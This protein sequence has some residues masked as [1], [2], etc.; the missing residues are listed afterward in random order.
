[1]NNRE[2]QQMNFDDLDIT[3]VMNDNID[4]EEIDGT[5][6]HPRFYFNQRTDE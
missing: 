3:N 6:N 4:F 5:N 1:M 2:E